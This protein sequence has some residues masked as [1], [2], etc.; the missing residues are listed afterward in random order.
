MKVEYSNYASLANRLKPVGKN[1]FIIVEFEG[2][3]K[4]KWGG[5]RT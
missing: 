2:A 1:A 5:E 4:E 3:A